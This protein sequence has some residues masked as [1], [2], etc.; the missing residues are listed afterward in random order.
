[1]PFR[2]VE[3]AIEAIQRGQR[4]DGARLLRAALADARVTGQLRAIALL[5]LAE[6][7]SD[8]RFR[9]AC[10][11]E[12]LEADPSNSDIQQRL[13]QLMN[14]QRPTTLPGQPPPARPHAVPEMPVARHHL[15]ELQRTVGIEGG[16]NG[17]AT[18]FF[19]SKDGLIATTRH[20]TRGLY[21][22]QVW[23]LSGQ[24]MSG[25]LVRAYPEYDLALI[26]ID[27]T[28]DQMLT[29]NRA[30]L[31]PGAAITAVWHN[32]QA[33]HSQRR[34]TKHQSSPHWFPTTFT[35]SLD[36]GG[37]PIFNQRSELVGMLTRSA[38][39]TSAYFYGLHIGLIMD[40]VRQY[41]QDQASAPATYCAS[42]G[43]ASRASAMGGFYC[44]N[45]GAVCQQAQTKQ[46]RPQPRL[47]SMYGENVYGPCPACQSAAGFYKGR[48]LRCGH[49]LSQPIVS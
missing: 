11:Q 12:A 42:C 18:G 30:D 4:D 20:A 35:E 26:Q 5:W 16:P 7:E 21:E 13:Q 36:A 9:Q 15:H 41:Q 28:L 32:G 47:A 49:D 3:Q 37:N 2:Q 48:C 46:R 29:A 23:L 22:A 31:A 25:R 19:V 14:A 17:S 1:M 33:R 27:V 34:D 8:Q 43:A 44:E 39:R 45:C 10:Y 38:N 40:C 6:T 24:V